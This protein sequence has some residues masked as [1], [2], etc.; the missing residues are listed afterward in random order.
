[1]S[2]V[3]GGWEGSSGSGGGMT[4]HGSDMH[5]ATVPRIKNPNLLYN[6]TGMMNMGGWISHPKVI[7]FRDE[8]IIDDYSYFL[9]T[10]NTENTNAMISASLPIKE[11]VTY[12]FSGEFEST[13]S[14]RVSILFQD[15]S[16]VNN[17]EE[18]IA[19]VELFSESFVAN[20]ARRVASFS[21]PSGAYCC[22]VKLE[23]LATQET[24]TAKYIRLKIEE[25]SVATD[26]VPCMSDPYQN[27]VLLVGMTASDL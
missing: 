22:C 27:N 4:V 19:A 1:M 17:P 12:T 23:H 21:A 18:N 3:S 15:S 20:G 6:S 7:N 25:G 24:N 11:G 5:D 10:G 8:F 26:W 16:N 13:D 14:I 9:V 2:W